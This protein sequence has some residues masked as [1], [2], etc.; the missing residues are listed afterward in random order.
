LN[1][2]GYNSSNNVGSGGQIYTHQQYPLAVS[3]ATNQVPGYFRTSYWI[4]NLIY[5]II[6]TFHKYFYLLNIRISSFSIIKN[7]VKKIVYSNFIELSFI[8]SDLK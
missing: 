3:Q 8:F 1:Q 2:L 7:L 5:Q 6:Y 4:N